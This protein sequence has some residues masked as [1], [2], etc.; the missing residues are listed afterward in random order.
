M[1]RECSPLVILCGQHNPDDKTSQGHFGEG[2]LY[3]N[4]PHKHNYKNLISTLYQ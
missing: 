4:L 2:K 3:P 1:K